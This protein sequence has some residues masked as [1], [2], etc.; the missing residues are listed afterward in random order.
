MREGERWTAGQ[1]GKKERKTRPMNL[2][3][4]GRNPAGFQRAA[5][6]HP[7]GNTTALPK[8]AGVSY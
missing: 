8:I 4:E 2:A 5:L 3:I 1:I 7:R 6:P